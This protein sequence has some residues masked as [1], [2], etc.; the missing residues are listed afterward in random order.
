VRFGAQKVG[1][2]VDALQ[3][4][5]QTVIKPL[6]ELFRHLSGISGS[7]I[8]GNGRVALII[9]V[10]GLVQFAEQRDERRYGRLVE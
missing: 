2:V 7:T 10:P 1:L 4:E 9:D 5:Q 3:G 8:L 6:G